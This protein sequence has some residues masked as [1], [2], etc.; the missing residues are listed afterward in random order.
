[1]MIIVDLIKMWTIWRVR[2]GQ[3]REVGGE[4]DRRKVSHLL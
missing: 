3:G 4:K 2:G 1:M